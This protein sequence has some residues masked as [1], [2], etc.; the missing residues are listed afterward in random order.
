MGKTRINLQAFIQTMTEQVDSLANIAT[1]FAQFAKTEKSQFT[2]VDLVQKIQ[3]IANL[4]SAD[5]C[6]IHFRSQKSKP[7]YQIRFYA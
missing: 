5:N 3:G 6:Q 2:T 1:A 7:N 4:F